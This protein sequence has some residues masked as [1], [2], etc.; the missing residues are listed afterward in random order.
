MKE[1]F[2]FIY[3]YYEY[4][5][6]LSAGLLAS[7]L[8]ICIGKQKLKTIYQ[9]IFTYIVTLSFDFTVANMCIHHFWNDR[10]GT[11][12]KIIAF[13]VENILA[14]FCCFIV[15]LLMVR[16]VINFSEKKGISDNVKKAVRDRVV[17]NKWGIGC[18]ILLTADLLT[19][20]P[21]K[22]GSWLTVWYI[23]DYSMGIGSRFFIGSLYSL[24]E[25][26]F[27]A[28]KDVYLFCVIANV[29]VITVFSILVN[30]LMKTAEKKYSK[31]IMYVLI[32]FLVSPGAISG[33]WQSDN[34][35]R[36]ETYGFLISLI[37][38]IVFEKCKNVYIRY[39]VVTFLTCISMAIYQGN[40]F[41]YY[42]MIL[43]L[44]VYDGLC[45][46]SDIWKRRALAGA[47]VI[48]TGATFFFFQFFSSVNFSSAEE[49]TEFL[50][51]KTDLQIQEM[52]I[53]FELFQPISVAFE[54]LN[55]RFLT[56][57]EMPRERAFVLLILLIPILVLVMALYMKCFRVRKENKIGMLKMPYIYYLL[58]GCAI[59][60][61]FLLNID[62]GR[63]ML[64]TM[65]VVFTGIFYL[66]YKKDAG[67]VS[68]MER[69]TVWLDTHKFV[70]LL[71]LA[72]IAGLG[73]FNGRGALA[74]VNT[75]VRLLTEWGLLTVQ[76]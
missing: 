65:I 11:K 24:F 53:D 15:A 10:Q 4:Y 63:W 43:M 59:I 29:L 71:V 5:F 30:E 18:W 37:S 8:A 54:L 62:W 45:A 20:L 76:G 73:K 75:I 17:R 52:A 28:T 51:Q 13:V 49:M 6:I 42:P 21:E 22:I 46:E 44:F 67:M 41:M 23:T 32:L 60:P 57:E 38:F 36:L 26:D 68:A 61:Q 33:M 9:R 31:G 16:I 2:E 19:T 70:G 55:T 27:I 3:D 66:T 56:G 69:L 48:L 35:G 50:M 74:E 39:F 7:F 34:F 1:I 14:F 25:D 64:A 72:H 47:N 58:I 12:E 40:I